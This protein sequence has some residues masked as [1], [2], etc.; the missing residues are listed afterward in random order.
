MVNLQ[1]AVSLQ[2]GTFWTIPNM[3]SLSRVALAG[4]VTVL[5]LQ[6]ADVWLVAGLLVLCAAT[7]WFDGQVARWTQSVT[8]WGKVLDPLADKIAAL[9]IGMALVWTTMLPMWIV[10]VIIARDVFIV[11]GGIALARAAGVVH[12]SMWLGKVAATAIGVTY[13][14]AVLH[15]SGPVMQ[16]CLWATATLMTLSFAQYLF[17]FFKL[18]CRTGPTA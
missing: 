2:L 6:R 5:V 10:A 18:R 7:D 11:A 13:L 9:S 12:A 17:R 14:A 1:R 15:A 3:L 16:I 8:G 4:L